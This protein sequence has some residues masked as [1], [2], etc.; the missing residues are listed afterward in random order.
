MAPPLKLRSGQILDDRFLLLEQ[1]GQGGMS[2]VFKAEDLDNDRQLVAVKV[3][4][5]QYSS[6]VGSWSMSQR[7]AEIGEKLC[8]PYILRFIASSSIEQRGYLVTELVSGDTLA[9]RVGKGKSLAEP[10]AFRLASQI[11]D[12]VHY[13]HTQQ[14]VHYDLKPGNIMLCQD[15]TIRL[16][17]FGVAHRSVTR[18]FAFAAAAPAIASSDYVAP[19]QIRRR[20][21]RPSVD[22]YALGAMLYEMLTGHAPFEDDDPFVVA[23]ARQIGDPRPLRALNPAVSAQAEEIVLRAL[24]RNPGER[25]L[26]VAA[27]KADLDHPEHVHVSGLCERLV[28]VTPWRK[29]LRL[30]RFVAF[31]GLVPIALMV[32]SFRVLWWYLARKP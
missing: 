21:G 23:S 10:E 30:L 32:A 1:I 3:P 16:I 27:L 7:E 15:G 5:P 11:C 24:R 26:S 20:R 9:T 8:H 28:A 18:R 25:Y 19:E 22:I 12:A 2:T 6:G 29:R 31:V 4:L 13:L 14:F 17:D